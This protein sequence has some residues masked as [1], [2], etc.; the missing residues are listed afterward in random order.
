MFARLANFFKKKIIK[1]YNKNCHRKIGHALLY[2]KTD[3]FLFSFFDWYMHTNNWEVLAIVKILNRLG[4]W[5]DILDRDID[6]KDVEKIEDKYDLF[7]GLG[8]GNS[9]KYFSDLAE[10]LTKAKKFFYAAGPEPELSNQL[11]LK[12]HDYFKARHP[13]SAIK[14]RRM[15]TEVHIDKAMKNTDGIF[16]I[17]NKFVFDSYEKY[18]KSIYRIY[19]SSSPKINFDLKQLG[20]LNSKKFLYFGGNGNIVKGLDLLLETF[21]KLPDLELYICA[22]QNE[23][24]FNKVYSDLLAKSK[25]IRFEGFIKVGGKKFNE[26]TSKCGFVILPSCSEGSATSVTTCMRRGLIPVVTY[27]SGIDLGDFGFLIEDTKIDK[28]IEQIKTFASIN[29]DEFKERSV[30]SYLESLK[31]TQA[32]FVNSFEKALISVLLRH[33]K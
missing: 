10:K 7:I 23:E 19:P 15:I 11:I 18:H 22:P 28:L 6:L 33:K 24:D 17:G 12:R 14:L 9:G 25:N 1:D 30:N 4:F 5:V 27:E 2:Y 21:E 13:K 29:P 8:A 20:G 31:Y 16:A 32:N 3:P 26:L